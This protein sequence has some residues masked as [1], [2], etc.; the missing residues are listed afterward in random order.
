[1]SFRRWRRFI[2]SF[3]VC[4]LIIAITGAVPASSLH[5]VGEDVVTL[6]P[7]LGQQTT[8]TATV[9]GIEGT[10]LFDTGEGLSTITP[11]FASRINC[12]PWGQVSG[13]RMS[14]ERLDT[15]HCDDL[16]L[17]AGREHMDLPVVGVLDLMKFFGPNA[18]VIDGALGLDAFAG[19]KITIIP[20]RS[21]IMETA[22]SFERRIRNGKE[23]PVRMV[24]DVEGLA[25]SIDGAVS[26]PSGTAWMELDTGNGG[27]LVI[28]NHIAPL[29]GMPTDVKEAVPVKFKLEN[30]LLVEGNAR[31]RSL[32]MD[33]N[34]GAQF[35]N[36]WQLSF[37]L[38]KGRAWF[39]PF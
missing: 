36:R 27:S 25:L 39:T 5:T 2:E 6:K 13:F 31:S 29:L 8:I 35:L 1:M 4:G 14:G 28:A 30:G 9:N 22:R 17:V 15:P 34:I 33:G 23:L 18:P 16:K 7:Y 38:E 11:A 3:A 19:R 32:I 20:R 21:L 10:F 12:K 24:R 37:D 26:T